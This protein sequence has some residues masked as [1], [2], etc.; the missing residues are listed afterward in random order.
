[1]YK[2]NRLKTG[3]V[4]PYNIT[5]SSTVS[6]KST[7]FISPIVDI[8]QSRAAL[9]KRYSLPN[10]STL[11]N[12]ENNSSTFNV[13]N[14]SNGDRLTVSSDSIRSIDKMNNQTI[15][16]INKEDQSLKLLSNQE[17]MKKTI[18]IDKNR[19][20]EQLNNKATEDAKRKATNQANQ[21]RLS[22]DR[23]SQKSKIGAIYLP[24]EFDDQFDSEFDRMMGNNSF[25]MLN[26]DKTTN[27][28]LDTQSDIDTR[29]S[30][31]NQLE[32][33]LFDSDAIN[34]ES[35]S[36]FDD[37]NNVSIGL[38]SSDDLKA[39]E[40]DMDR[41]LDALLESEIDNDD[42]ELDSTL[43]FKSDDPILSQYIVKPV[44]IPIDHDNEFKTATGVPIKIKMTDEQQKAKARALGLLK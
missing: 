9:M 2:T 33:E 23:L 42:V 40:N 31:E 32:E 27:A 34:N 39:I 8:E 28:Q 21:E 44:E 26:D 36:Q 41:E 10:Q 14:K 7:Q 38:L 22:Q 29:D 13:I 1:M 24:T 11:I 17:S 4:N 16:R 43:I 15:N 18:E 12:S 37:L 30:Q 20:N 25:S 5:S 35:D 19:P 6:R 3:R